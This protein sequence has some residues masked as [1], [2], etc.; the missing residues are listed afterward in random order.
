MAR[1]KD[2]SEVNARSVYNQIDEAT[3]APD[4]QDEQ[5][6][7][8]VQKKPRKTYTAEERLQRMAEGATQGCKGIKLRRINM[9]F[10]PEVYDYISTMARVRGE[11]IA[12]FT[13]YI[14]TRS[15]DEN[16]EIYEKAKAFRESL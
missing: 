14:F 2:F 16:R 7:Q 10:T 4:Q 1:K 13:R 11:S 12:T 3:A 15:M 5:Q 9:G 8:E 6:A